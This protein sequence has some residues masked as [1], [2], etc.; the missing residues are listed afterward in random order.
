[1]EPMVKWVLLPEYIDVIEWV[2]YIN[3]EIYNIF[4]I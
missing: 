3:R 2:T 4:V 1:M